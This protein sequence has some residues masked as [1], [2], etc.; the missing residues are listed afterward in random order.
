M[1]RPVSRHL[2]IA[3]TM[4]E[5]AGVGPL[6]VALIWKMRKINK[7]P[8]FLYVGDPRPV[9]MHAPRLPYKNVTACDQ[10]HEIFSSALPVWPVPAQ[11]DFVAGRP[12]TQTAFSVIESIKTAVELCQVGKARALVTNPIHKETLLKAGFRYSG[13]TEYLGHLT[14]RRP[15]MMLANDL[16]RTIPVTVHI[17]LRKASQA[18]SQDLIVST[19]KVA[20]RDLQ[21][22]FGLSRPRLAMTGLNPHAGEGGRLGREE[23]STIRPAL[24]KLARQGI[25]VE[26][27]LPAD[28]AF[29]QSQRQLFDCYFAMTH[30]QALIPVKT[31][32]FHGTVNVT[33]GLPWIRTSPAH[34]VA[35][36]A[37]GRK[38]QPNTL[39][40]QKALHM[41]AKLSGM[42]RA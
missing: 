8:A 32:D 16:L 17:P 36:E 23:I 4:G 19:V 42:L 9:L 25:R 2:P 21:Q 22:R 29:S 27:P 20:F 24:R 40:L 1:A 33:L 12:S 6:A 30:D 14:K 7:L 28:S 34:G 35:L 18:L 38:V 26:G 3:L 11:G 5:P 15:V 41:A 10:I 39:S 31:L 13:H 37:M